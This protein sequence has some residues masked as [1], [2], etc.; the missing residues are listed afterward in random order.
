MH[1][2]PQARNSLSA[3]ELSERHKVEPTNLRFV[4]Y[5]SYHGGNSEAKD[6]EDIKLECSSETYKAH[7]TSYFI[8]FL[9]TWKQQ[10]VVKVYF[11]TKYRYL[12]C[13]II[14]KCD[15]KLQNCIFSLSWNYFFIFCGLCLTRW[16][17][18]HLTSF[19]VKFWNLKSPLKIF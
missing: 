17:W 8:V 5:G 13:F 18:K 1:P 16:I 14:P 11:R 15:V 2:F 19:H 9:M 10:N 6:E 7:V 3:S 12:I 4:P